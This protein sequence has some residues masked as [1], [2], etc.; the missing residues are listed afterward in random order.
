[1]AYAILRI[2]KI[3]SHS[4]AT[5]K[6]QH[7]Y[8][9]Q[10][11][12][13][14]D[15]EQFS[16]N[17]ELL[18]QEQR[19][20]WDLAQERIREVGITRV[21]RDAVCA[22][23]VLLTGS[24]EAFARDAQGKAQDVRGSAWVQDNLH[25]L[26]QRYG[27]RN[28]VSFTLHQDELT[29]HIH[30]VVIPITQQQRLHQGERVGA[31]ERL[32]CRD[33]FGPTELRKLQTDYA[34]AMAPYGMERGVQ[35]STAI[36]QDVRRHYGAQRTTQ[37][38]L[39]EVA[40]PVPHTTRTPSEPKWYEWH[41][42]QAVVARQVEETTAHAAQQLAEANAKLTQLAE[43][44]T[45][46]ALAHDRARVLEKQLA[47]SKAQHEQTKALLAQQQQ[48]LAQKSTH[49][50]QLVVRTAQGQALSPA[51]VDQVRQ[52]QEQQRQRAEQV[53]GQVLRGPVTEA[54]Q[55][56]KALQQAGYVL[57]LQPDQTLGVRHTATAVEFPLA[58]LR[59]NGQQL[60]T[61]LQQAIERTQAEQEQQRRE[62]LAQNPAAL[63]AVIQ[64]RD[65]QQATRIEEAL[66]KAGANVWS[67]EAL[68]EQR[69]TLRVSYF[70]D[71]QTI[72]SISRVLDTVRR[73]SGAQL[74]ESLGHHNSRT[75]AVRT[76]ER[77]R[78]HTRR[79]PE[80]GMGIS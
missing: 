41:N 59:P 66:E 57:Y 70:F 56:E 52:L 49:Y 6:T 8:R 14:A 10:N 30:A 55:V 63:H 73:S 36:H 47:T 69:V 60:L 80:R 40:M 27:A 75:S 29:P 76:L 1:M 23:E 79:G 25:F 22:V 18:N 67:R 43:V 33:V 44:A 62:K 15:P 38:R 12:P 48:Q 39:A 2:G 19:N 28:V 50:T 24:P 72:E 11:T 58:T 34:K 3:K 77:E 37:Q 5:S 74:E 16:R 32:S 46:N 65:T 53:A 35:Y 26:Q 9:T 7:N 68:P 42:P 61:Q 51:L 17:Q 71:W 31:A 45:A 64:A 21:R 54:G 78:E 13:N 20:Y 4:S